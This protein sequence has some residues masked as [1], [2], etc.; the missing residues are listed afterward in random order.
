MTRASKK[1]FVSLSIC[2]VPF[3]F[4]W[5]KKHMP[6]DHDEDDFGETQW[7]D[8]RVIINTDRCRSTRDEETTVLHE[9]L[10][11]I[12]GVCGHDKRFSDEEEERLV[13]CF[14]NGLYPV[15]CEL[16][17]L[18]YFKPEGNANG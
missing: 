3:S 17:R 11:A 15:I 9:I 7:L 1:R 4:S 8:R 5:G 16:V 13:T 2:G 12:V 10:H 14:E 6:A 18:G